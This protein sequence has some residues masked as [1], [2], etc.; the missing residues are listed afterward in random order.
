MILDILNGSS[1]LELV[2]MIKN[3]LEE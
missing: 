3:W 2:Q 1:D